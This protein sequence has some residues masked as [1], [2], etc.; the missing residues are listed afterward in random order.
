MN[1]D[2]KY[3]VANQ[4]ESIAIQ[5]M[6]LD[7]Q[8]V[9]AKQYPR[10]IEKFKKTALEII[11]SNPD[12]AA[13]CNYS[14]TIG[15]DIVEGPSIRLAEIVASTWGN[16]RVDCKVKNVGEKVVT[17]E[18]VCHDLESNLA[19]RIETT[20]QIWS[21]KYGRYSENMIQTTGMAGIS[22]VFRNS[23]F[24]VVPHGFTNYL[25]NEAKKVA[26]GGAALVDEKKE[27]W[28]QHFEKSGIDR[29]RIFAKFKVNSI[30]EMTPDNFHTLSGIA[31]ALRDNQ[32]TMENEFPIKEP[33]S[34]DDE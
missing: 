32:T 21:K 27:I 3:P 2:N 12:I 15:D 29:T 4:T 7:T 10:D 18:A 11:K 23:I 33:E 17:L 25:R 8:I 19:I 34:T 28:L 1:K 14:R 6:E 26:M 9:T 20:R 5:K 22:I 13:E 30:N 31:N 16:L 24:K